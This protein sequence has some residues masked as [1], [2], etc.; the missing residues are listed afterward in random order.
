MYVVS[1][2]Y[3]QRVYAASDGLYKVHAA[4]KAASAQRTGRDRQLYDLFAALNAHPSV[5]PK[6]TVT[7]EESKRQPAFQSQQPDPNVQ[8][9][10]APT[11]PDD[12]PVNRGYPPNPLDR[13]ALG[14][15]FNPYGRFKELGFEPGSAFAF[16]KPLGAAEQKPLQLVRA[17]ADRAY[18]ASSF[19]LIPPSRA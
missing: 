17:Q 10:Q 16:Q 11:V 18:R 14:R 3:V 5:R 19:A 13:T 15:P 9:E 12:R 4:A 8:D 6:T 2:V 7:G 1:P